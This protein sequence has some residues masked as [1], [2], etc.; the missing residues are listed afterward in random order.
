MMHK[1]EEIS[2]TTQGLAA[3]G[4]MDVGGLQYL[5]DNVIRRIIAEGPAQALRAKIA[6]WDPLA[7]GRYQA[8]AADQLD[9]RVLLDWQHHKNYNRQH[10][11][12][13]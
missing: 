9:A 4:V 1:R 13:A 3:F 12:I 11:V 2:V 10:W 7:P 5:Y 6:E 8:L